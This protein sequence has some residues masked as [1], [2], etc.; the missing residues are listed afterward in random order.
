MTTTNPEHTSTEEGSAPPAGAL[1][2][3]TADREQTSARLHAAA[4]EGFLSMAEVEERLAT[5]YAARYR[6]ELDA[7][8]AD[9]PSANTAA[10]WGA[11]L[12]V[13]RR[14]LADDLAALT[15]R[16]D[17]PISRRRKAVLGLTALLFVAMLVFLAVHGF[18]DE[19]PEH[20]AA[21]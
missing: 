1:R 3:S 17:H 11:I 16:G 10:G 19:G 2:C 7:V 5:T 14:Q 13:A 9:L 6:H 21:D 4:G 18:A 20:H 8:T 15:G 12:T